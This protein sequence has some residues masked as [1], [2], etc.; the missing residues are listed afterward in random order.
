[1][2]AQDLYI[3][4]CTCTTVRVA[5]VSEKMKMNSDEMDKTKKKEK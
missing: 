5:L 2:R 4:E 3:M 1:M